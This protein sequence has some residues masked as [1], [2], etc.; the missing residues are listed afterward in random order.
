LLMIKQFNL[1]HL[2]AV[3]ELWVASLDLCQQLE[4]PQW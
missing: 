2:V 3:V 1:V 4:F